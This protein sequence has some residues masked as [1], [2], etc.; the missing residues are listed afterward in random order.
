MPFVKYN[1]QW[2]DGTSN[3]DVLFYMIRQPDEFLMANGITRASLY[4]EAHR[5]LWP[6]DDQHRWFTLGMT[7]IVENQVTVLVGPA[8]S[9][10]THTM[11]CH[12]LITFFVHPHN[13]FS[14]ISSTEGR[15]LEI[16]VWGRIKGLYNRAKLRFPWLPGYILDAAKAITAS[17]IDDDNELARQLN[18]GL[19]CVP[20]VS[21][22]KF[23]GMSK[24]QGT[25]P[26]HTPGKSDGLLTHYGD[27]AA[28]MQHSFLDAYSNWMANGPAF[29]G[30]MSGNP[31]DVSDPLCVAAEPVGGWDA[32]E[33][34][35]KTQEW[36]SRWHNAAVIAFDGRD[37]PNNDDDK[38]QYPYL[39]TRKHIQSL[40]E[41]YGEDSW[42]YFQQ[43]IGKPSKGMVSNRVIT[44]AQCENHHAFESALW[45]GSEIIDLFAVD[46]AFTSSGDRCV[47]GR[48]RMGLSMDGVQILDI[49]KPEIIPI[50]FNSRLE[51]SEQIA[52]W[53]K[54][55][56]DKLNIPPERIFYDSLGSTQLGFA[57]S[58]IYGSSSPVPVESGGQPS[59]RPVRFDLWVVDLVTKQKRLKTC[60]EQY[61][62]LITEMWFSV[63]EAVLSDQI[64]GM[65]REI[66]L[67]GQLR[68][69]EVLPNN[70][71]AV[72]SKEDMK[73]R[74]R[75][76]PDLFDFLC[77]IPTTKIMTPSGDK[78]IQYLS[79]GDEVVT[80]FGN[81]R[82]ATVHKHLTNEIFTA[83]L[84]DGS[85]ITGKG[86]HKIFT[87]DSGWVRL[88]ELSI[89]NEIESKYNLPVWRM[90]NLLFEKEEHI[91]FKHLVDI[92]KTKTGA[93]S[94]KDF[95]IG[96]SGLSA[97]GL[98]LMGF[99]SIIKMVVGGITAF[100]IWSW[101]ILK[102][103]LE[104]IYEKD[105][106]IQRSENYFWQEHPKEEFKQPNGMVPIL[107]GSGILKTRCMFGGILENQKDLPV[108]FVGCG[109][110]PPA[111]RKLLS[112]VQI[113]ANK[114]TLGSALKT[115]KEFVVFVV[116]NLLRSNTMT[117]RIAPV[118]V[119]RSPSPE[120]RLVINLTLEEHNIYYANGI[121]V[122]NC[123][124]VEGARRL[125]FKIQ[126]IGSNSKSGN[127]S[128]N[129][130]NDMRKRREKLLK[131][132]QLKAA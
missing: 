86:R 121:L 39:I 118:T 124:G 130:L 20:C 66:A 64:R 31:T 1:L 105:G 132:K 56:C 13:S 128:T 55:K 43:G 21:G 106:N 94:R 14:M 113:P 35:K 12:A 98:F 101:S 120:S 3:L 5:E 7:R 29:K 88:D 103:T 24:F 59:D 58:K 69:F 99:K 30:V 72:E 107:E 61:D 102:N 125:G 26:P 52:S 42:Q 131:S 57:F 87:L 45:V 108:W 62:R 34:A 100:P 83:E 123:I 2:P 50:S 44:V 71:T 79:P 67:E 51:A 25:K 9:A 70:K 129:W 80:P 76:S 53:V 11:A 114:S 38:K 85:A 49:G 23:V 36:R 111:S 97:T 89:D 68:M 46:P 81:T 73:E 17:D 54:N 4:L 112:F 47:G 37:T 33:D 60:K 78:E 6:E 48:L 116:V 110:Q 18:S 75:K 77:W 91:A 19:I 63:A 41:T 84:S 15:S 95:Y 28:T 40:A 22:G 127:S 126:R 119:R 90:L 32:F 104:I 8:S 10:K 65:A 117:R 109:S 74:V 93:V 16:K 115:I 27:E 92:I 122:E 82:I 96:L